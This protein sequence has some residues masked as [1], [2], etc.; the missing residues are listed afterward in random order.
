MDIQI[1]IFAFA[2][3][4]SLVTV[5][6]LIFYKFRPFPDWH[7]Q[8]TMVWGAVVVLGLSSAIWLIYTNF[9]IIVEGEWGR[10]DEL[11]QLFAFGPIAVSGL[12]ASFLKPR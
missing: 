5:I 3:L 12:V 7:H 4:G 10:I 1:F 2:N 8:L 11:I 9:P 6:L